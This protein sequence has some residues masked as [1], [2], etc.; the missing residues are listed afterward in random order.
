MS[1]QHPA[2]APTRW[3]WLAAWPV[4][5][6]FVLSNAV[7]P[8]YGVWQ[9]DIG[10]SQGTLTVIFATYMAGLITSLLISGNLS[11]RIGRRPVLLPAIALALLACL[12]FATARSVPALLAG[13]LLTGLAIGAIVSAGMAAVTDIA[14]DQRRRLAALLASSGM[15][16]GAGTGPLLAGVLS[17]YAPGPTH[18]VFAVEAALLGTALLVV[19]RMPLPPVHPTTAP[20]R[21]IR[22]PS[23]PRPNRRQLLLGIAV[24]A[25]GITSTSFVLALGPTLLSGL[26]GNTSRVLAGAMAFAM[27]FMGT[28]AQF[29]AVRWSVRRILLTGVAALLLGLATLAGAVP[30][31]S[32]AALMTAA[33]LLGAGQGLGQLGGLSLL[34]SSVPTTR[35]AEANAALNTAGYLLAGAL[36]V[37][38]GY[39]SDAVGLAPATTAFTTLMAVLVLAGGLFVLSPGSRAA[40][41]RTRDRGASRGSCARSG[42]SVPV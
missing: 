27:F 29:A 40:G 5:A 28:V 16:L 36:P 38:T 18:T 21:W 14:G 20:G 12:V 2:H 42:G 23:V 1:A 37:A 30:A 26:L 17:E 10:F 31:T 39:L 4:V 3:I 24:F 9:R 32:E 13:R 7:S 41:S 22:V 35:L 8:L 34:N 19:L 11:D 6:V 33:L 15:V 25:P